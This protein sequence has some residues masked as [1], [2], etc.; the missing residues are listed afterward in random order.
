M[1]SWVFVYVRRRR[2]PVPLP[3]PLLTWVLWAAW[4]F[5]VHDHNHIRLDLPRSYYINAVR[6]ILESTTIVPVWKILRAAVR[7]VESRFANC[8]S[9]KRKRCGA[10]TRTYPKTSVYLLDFQD[11]QQN[12][13]SWSYK[14]EGIW[15]M[16]KVSS[17]VSCAPNLVD[18]LWLCIVMIDPGSVLSLA[19]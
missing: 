8:K 15:G 14:L 4:S 13:S 11:C 6:Q 10:V 16:C 3:L 19:I 1:S 2:L 18:Y 9:D 12:G 17:W 7:T 5:H